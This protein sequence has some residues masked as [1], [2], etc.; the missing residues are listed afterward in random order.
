MKLKV[1]LFLIIIF[2]LLCNRRKEQFSTEY[3]IMKSKINEIIE[4]L[5]QL[6][7]AYPKHEHTLS[8]A[9]VNTYAPEH[10]K[11]RDKMIWNSKDAGKSIDKL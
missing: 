4:R 1:V 6:L 8:D 10:Y 5:N 2:L 3:D 11:A 7:S 9:G